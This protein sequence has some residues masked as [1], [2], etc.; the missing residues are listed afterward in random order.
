MM[1]LKRATPP[2]VPDLI[3]IYRSPYPVLRNYKRLMND[4]QLEPFAGGTH[5]RQG[6]MQPG[7]I[8]SGYRDGTSYLSPHG[9]AVAL[10][11]A[12]GGLSLQYRAANIA[13]RYFERVGL[14]PQNGFI[15]VDLFDEILREY[16]KK[17]RFWVR[18]NGEYTAFDDLD[19]A[20]EYVDDM[21]K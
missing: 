19:K 2:D 15:H 18:I 5:I 10:D 14:Y 16:Y 3:T 13:I 21:V 8:I 17:K 12:I 11:I 1:G 9:F 20:G 7:L 6:R 4:L